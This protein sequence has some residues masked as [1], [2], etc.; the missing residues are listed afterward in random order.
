MHR[1]AQISRGLNI[2]L[3]ELGERVNRGP[4]SGLANL[5]G[6]CLMQPWWN[7]LPSCYSFGGCQM[8]FPHPTYIGHSHILAVCVR[9]IW[10]AYTSTL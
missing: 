3:V 1:V 10:L 8:V 6:R 5:G 9:T 7:K 4:V 2:H